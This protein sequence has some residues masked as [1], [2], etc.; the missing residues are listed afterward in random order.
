MRQA[1]PAPR[2]SSTHAVHGFQTSLIRRALAPRLTVTHVH[3][4]PGWR[5]LR[6]CIRRTSTS[7]VFR[8]GW[9]CFRVSTHVCA[10]VRPQ[11]PALTS[12]TMGTTG[13]VPPSSSAGGALAP[14][15]CSEHIHSE[16]MASPA[17]VSSLVGMGEAELEPESGSEIATASGSELPGESVSP[18]EAET[19]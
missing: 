14:P 9:N 18:R 10:C 12:K 17:A 5:R 7:S 16:H 2:K 4:G 19:G 6:A 15:S 3:D 11:R 8:A 13:L 1:S